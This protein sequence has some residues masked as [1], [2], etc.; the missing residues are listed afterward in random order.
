MA[1]YMDVHNSLPEGA[2]AADVAGAHAA[3]LQVQGR[4][5]V[6]YL[7]YWVDEEGGK[8]FCL[9]EA[10]SADAAHAVHREAHG[11]VADEIYPVSQG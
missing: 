1:L 4:F 6:R 8:V 5:G 10:P 2:T 9:I 7:S 3:D 11:L